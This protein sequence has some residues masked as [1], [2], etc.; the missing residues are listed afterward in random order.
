MHAPR[1][2]FIYYSKYICEELV[3]LHL[4]KITILSAYLSSY[5]FN[6]YILTHLSSYVFNQ[7]CFNKFQYI[8][9]FFQM[10]LLKTLM[11]FW[12]KKNDNEPNTTATTGKQGQKST[13]T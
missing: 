12:P 9:F 8:Y 4:G 1:N 3:F 6:V 5:S 13:L 7:L 10:L 2:V 11:C